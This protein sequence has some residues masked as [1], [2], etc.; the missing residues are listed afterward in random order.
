[1]IVLY[2]QLPYVLR[3]LIIQLL[4]IF[5]LVQ[6]ALNFGINLGKVFEHV[7]TLR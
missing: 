3:H 2:K 4:L 6:Y 7:S 1:M 5:D